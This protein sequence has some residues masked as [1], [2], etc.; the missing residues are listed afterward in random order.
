VTLSDDLKNVVTL[1]HEYLGR[2]FETGY[3]I[4]KGIFCD[5][6]YECCSNRGV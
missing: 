4:I 1:C 2:I 3:N 6:I 5:V